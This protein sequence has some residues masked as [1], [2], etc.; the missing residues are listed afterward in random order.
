MNYIM[1]NWLIIFIISVL[2]IYGF[3]ALKGSRS[4]KERNQVVIRLLLG[5]IM[6]Y[7]IALFV[8]IILGIL[9]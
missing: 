5:V 1:D 4:P 7:L 6:M 3:V 2:L 9:M 8:L